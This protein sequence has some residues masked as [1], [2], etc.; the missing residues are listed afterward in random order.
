MAEHIHE[1]LKTGDYSLRKKLLKKYPRNDSSFPRSAIPRPKKVALLWKTSRP[2]TVEDVE[3]LARERKA[4]RPAR[5]RRKKRR[6]YSESDR[7]LQEIRRPL[8]HQR[9]GRSSRKDRRAYSQRSAN[10]STGHAGRI[11]AA[12]QRNHRRSRF[13][14]HPRARKIYAKERRS[15][16][17]THPEISRTSS[18]SWRTAKIKSA[19]LLKNGLQVDVRMLE[20]EIYGAALLY[21][22][23]SKEHNVVLRGRAN[24]MG[25]TLNEYALATLKGE[26]P[27]AAQDRRGNLR[28]AGARLHRARIARKH[29]RNRSR[30]PSIAFRT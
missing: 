11:A 7:S 14:C 1:I 30:R 8:S 2:A 6:K 15:I 25:Y 28:Q 10:P 26:R 9:G 27:V 5:L 21:F 4:A 23:G 19:S 24:K 17:R 22:T 18:K 3:K 20:K 29:R 13:A 12:R 16:C